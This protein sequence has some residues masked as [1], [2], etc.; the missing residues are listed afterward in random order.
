MKKIF[1]L[2]SKSLLSKLALMAI[3]I[4]GGGDSAWGDN[5]SATLTF[6]NS[7]LPTGWVN[8]GVYGLSS[9]YAEFDLHDGY[10]E[11]KNTYNTFSL[12]S[13]STTLSFSS[14]QKII[15]TAKVKSGYSS[16]SQHVTIRYNNNGSSTYT[17]LKKFDKNDYSSQSDYTILTYTLTS[18]YAACRLQFLSQASIISKIEIQDIESETITELTLDENDVTD[19]SSLASTATIPDVY[20]KYTP[21]N[22][23]NTICMPFQLKGNVAASTYMSTIFGDSWKAY[24]LN[25]YS[26]GVITFSQRTQNFSMF[27]N[28][29]YLVYST[30]PQEVPTDGFH[31]EDLEVTY[32]ENPYSAS[33]GAR[34]QG[35]YAPIT[36]G[37]FTNEMY[38]VTS[39]GQVRP[40]DGINAN[41]KG[42]RAYFTGVSAPAGARITL[43]FEDGDETTDLGFVKMVDP[44]ATDVYTLSGQKVKK[45]SKGIYIVNGRKVVIK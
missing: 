28:T 32:S 37:N 30:T 31:F 39:S 8:G 15:V 27:K 9:G 40:G 13:E 35:T 5:Y 12:T 4:V 19:F 29:P 34:F 10:I 45:G 44:E 6:E 21:T 20:V 36:A 11:C 24:S 2:Y 22:G 25:N 7:T 38:G 43:V 18:D 3:L 16:T 1:Y 42:Y 33:N 17:Q 23:W 26:D 14:G 41:M